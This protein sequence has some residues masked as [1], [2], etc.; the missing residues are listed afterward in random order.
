M[1]FVYRIYTIVGFNFNVTEVIILKMS[2]P[3]KRKN[4]SLV[5]VL[6]SVE[7]FDFQNYLVEI[8]T[9]RFDL[10][11]EVDRCMKF[12]SEKPI[13]NE[14]V[15][16]SLRIASHMRLDV[17][18]AMSSIV[19]WL[20]QNARKMPQIFLL[21]NHIVNR[22]E[23]P[24]KIKVTSAQSVS[25]CTSE[26]FINELVDLLLS[27]EEDFITLTANSISLC[28]NK[29]VNPVTRRFQVSF[30]ESASECQD[31]HVLSFHEYVSDYL[32]PTVVKACFIF[33]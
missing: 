14:E 20:D 27:V 10:W 28:L 32:K 15:L 7:F 19:S 2:V 4:Y 18:P 12:F 6:P 1:L 16:R 17:Y 21:K 5:S 31:C 26:Y 22:I 25:F 24:T 3:S 9:K 23:E 29:Y 8:G 11:K 30:G 33:S 13:V